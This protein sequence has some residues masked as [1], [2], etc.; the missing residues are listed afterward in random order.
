MLKLEHVDFS[1]SKDKITIKDV[2]FAVNKK[3]IA[4]L[5]GPNGVG[6]STVLNCIIAV[7]KINNGNIYFDEKNIR[8]I[9]YKDKAKYLSYVPQLIDG[10]DLTVKETILLGRLSHFKIYP[11][12]DDYLKVDEIIHK[13]NLENIKDKPTN[14]IS[15]GERQKVAIARA[16]IQDSE[17]ILF[18]EPTSNLDIKSQLEIVNLIKESC[19]E[20]KCSLISMHDIN[21]AL[22]LGDKF[23]FLKDDTIYKI[24]NKE[25]INE[26]LLFDVYGVNIK[27]INH[28]GE[29]IIVYEKDD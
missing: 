27:L 25:E 16:L 15:G 8:E 21:L 3:E 14:Q 17:I 28:K 5:L 13:F 20:N 6:K 7:N 10:N 1:Y 24:C 18:D 22:R 12:K 2:T 11:N 9:S 23:I 26:Q 4:I 19:K 29:K